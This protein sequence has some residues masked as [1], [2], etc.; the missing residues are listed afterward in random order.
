MKYTK[1]TAK[2]T[3]TIIKM[4][5]KGYSIYYIEKQTST[6][7]HLVS[8]IL[9]INGITIRHA[10]FYI[11][12]RKLT[13]KQRRS[14]A[15]RLR[16]ANLGRAPYNKLKTVEA[17]FRNYKSNAKRRNKRFNISRKELERLIFGNCFYCGGSPSNTFRF[18]KD[19]S[20]NGIDRLDSSRGYIKN[21]CVSCCHMCNIMKNDYSLEEFLNQIHK[22]QL[23][24]NVI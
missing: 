10:G 4:Y 18:R 23:Y 15:E 20:I 2:L 14:M 3:K 5:K 21:N 6:E 8:K 22:I 16:K 9:R 24:K 19:I 17:I 13:K 7:R 1:I 11:K 12:Y